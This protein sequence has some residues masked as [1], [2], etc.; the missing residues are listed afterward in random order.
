MRWAYRQD[1]T[2]THWPDWAV[3]GLWNAERSQGRGIHQCLIKVLYHALNLG[4]SNPTSAIYPKNTSLKNHEQYFYKIPHYSTNYN[5]KI[6][7]ATYRLVTSACEDT[8]NKTLMMRWPERW[9][10]I[11]KLFWRLDQDISRID[12]TS[13]SSHGLSSGLSLL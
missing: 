3:T 9:S 6:L 2:P 10:F 1:F 5:S 13:L 11:F 7:A 4:P 12:F 8:N